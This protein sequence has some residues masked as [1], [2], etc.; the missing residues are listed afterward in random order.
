M[1]GEVGASVKYASAYVPNA[2]GNDNRGQ[3]AATMKCPIVNG[4]G[5]IWNSKRSQ[6]CTRTEC[7][8]TDF[9]DSH[10]KSH[11]RQVAAILE[12]AL[13]NRGDSIWNDEVDQIAAIL[14]HTNS[15][16]LD[17][18]WNHNVCQA[19]AAVKRHAADG[20]NTFGYDNT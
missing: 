14:E 10:R 8:Y 15:D 18:R 20:S 9:G 16:A 11:I 4:C 2:A 13:L 7:T 17:A 3:T 1:D 12:H 6:R 19:A 5:T